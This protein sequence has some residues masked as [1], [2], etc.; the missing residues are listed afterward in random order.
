MLRHLHRHLNQSGGGGHPAVQQAFGWNMGELLGMVP[1]PGGGTRPQLHKMLAERVVET[2]RQDAAALDRAFFAGTPMSDALEA[3]P[4]QAVA[5]A[6]SFMATDHYD[7]TQ[8]R[9]F[10]IWAEMV[11]RLMQAD[12][13]HFSWAIRAP[14]QRG[15]RSGFRSVNQSVSQ[16]ASH[17]A[18][19]KT[20]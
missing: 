7:V 14:E 20:P 8:L 10:D 5:T 16:S 1:C 6:Q 3:A 15:S 19:S 13:G 17:S 2:Y 9:H 12:P 18:G 4:G 11:S